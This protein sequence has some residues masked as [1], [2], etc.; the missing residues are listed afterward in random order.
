M[1]L[2]KR[3]IGIVIGGFLALIGFGGI[4][5]MTGNS[6]TR[7]SGSD[8]KDISIVDITSSSA[9]VKWTTGQNKQGMLLYGTSQ[10]DLSIE[11][12]MK[13]PET[14]A[15][16][17]HLLTIENLADSTTYYFKIFTDENVYDNGGVPWNFTTRSKN[18]QSLINSGSVKPKINL[19]VT[20]I[21]RLRIVDQN[22]PASNVPVVDNAVVAI[23]RSNDCDMIKSY[24]AK[25]CRGAD[26]SRCMSQKKPI[27]SPN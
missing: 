24:L 8:P 4:F 12:S 27:S 15:T 10:T 2:S 3:T 17:D 18:E 19:S 13:Q 1:Q 25:G 6:L 9:T 21:Q 16:Q 22:V 26:W 5:F 11:K 20:P 14:E 23:C 7:A